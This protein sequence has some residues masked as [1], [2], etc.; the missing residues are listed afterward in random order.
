M[1]AAGKRRARTRAA[2]YRGT[3]RRGRH[4]AQLRHG[5]RGPLSVRVAYVAHARRSPGCV[6]DLAR[7]LALGAVRGHRG[8]RDR[9]AARRADAHRSSAVHHAPLLDPSEPVGHRSR[10]ARDRVRANEDKAEE[11]VTGYTSRC[12]SSSSSSSSS[13]PPHEKRLLDQPEK[14]FLHA[15]RSGEGEAAPA[16]RLWPTPTRTNSSV[17]HRTSPTGARARCEM[18]VFSVVSNIVFSRPS[19]RRSAQCAAPMLLA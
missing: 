9:A 12:C 3:A 6:R 17:R 18:H 19:A 1:G 15:L 11:V 5:L 10:A 2:R 16:A 14:S 8:R 7:V 13:P 4:G